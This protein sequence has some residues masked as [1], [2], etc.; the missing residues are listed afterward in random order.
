[1]SP[2][3]NQLRLMSQQPFCLTESPDDRHL[4]VLGQEFSGNIWDDREFIDRREVQG[5]L[6][7]F[8]R[9]CSF[10]GPRSIVWREVTMVRSQWSGSDLVCYARL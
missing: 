5:S 4:A 8:C 6:N 10:R 3:G 1:M 2:R 9:A 7:R